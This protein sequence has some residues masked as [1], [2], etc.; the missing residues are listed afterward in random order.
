[1]RYTL[2][3][4][5][6]TGDGEQY[7]DDSVIDADRLIA[8]LPDALRRV[9]NVQYVVGATAKRRVTATPQL[10]SFTALLNRCALHT[11]LRQGNDSARP[12]C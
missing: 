4:P 10:Q 11:S 3:F 2:P 6:D 8:A 12:L 1:M 5:S 7:V 9:L